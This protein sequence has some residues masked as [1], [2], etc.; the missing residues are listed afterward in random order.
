[1]TKISSIKQLFLAVFCSLILTTFNVPAHGGNPDALWEIISMDCVPN[2]KAHRSP[3]PCAEV[4]FEPD[5]ERGYAVLKDHNGPLQYLLLP[6]TKIT[7]IESPEVLAADSPNYFY[8]AWEARSYMEKIYRSPIAP[9]EISLTV[10]SQFGRSQNQLHIHI[11]CTRP[12]VRTLVQRNLNHIGPT[13]SEF[14]GGIFGHKYLSRRITLQQLKE[15]NSFQFLANDFP[16]AKTSMYEFG[17]AVVAIKTPL[18]GVD[19]VL[20]ADRAETSKM[21][22]GHVEEI[23]DHHCPQLFSN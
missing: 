13:W 9:E 17:L 2:Q 15:Q 6:T 7:G 16:G 4:S 23:Q 8:H 10:N 21:D 1:M 14:P 22:K 19:F 20:L 18:G 12:N 11:S 5:G 3:D